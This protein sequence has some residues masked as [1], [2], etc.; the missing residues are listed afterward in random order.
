MAR[1]SVHVPGILR[2]ADAIRPYRRPCRRH[3]WHSPWHLLILLTLLLPL[4]LLGPAY[5][6]ERPAE[7]LIPVVHVLRADDAIYRLAAEG[8]YARVVQVFPWR[9]I[10]PTRGEWH[11]QQLDFA[12]R[13]AEYYGLGLIVRLDHPP[14]WALRPAGDK[15]ESPFDLDAYANFVATVARRYRGQVGAYII[16]NEPNLG[17]EWAG[18]R[19]DPVAY[20]ALLCWAYAALKAADPGATVVSAGLAPTNGGDAALDDRLFLRQMLEAGA[21]RCFDVLGAHAYSFGHP[22]DDPHGAHDGLNLARLLDL[23]EIMKAHGE[24]GKPVWITEIGWTTD[25]AGAHAWQT[26]SPEQ[27]AAYLMEA[28]RLIAEEWPWVQVLTIWNLSQGLPAGDEMAGYSLLAADGHP[29]PAYDAMRALL[30]AER[31]PGA[32]D[33]IECLTKAW[34]RAQIAEIPILAADEIVHLGDNQ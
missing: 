31:G 22:P 26:V 7:G 3:G 6:M 11:W 13:A 23:R 20:T 8:G 17:A 5:A 9:D 16:W 33:W 19:P 10:E 14:D 18:Q 15:G 4:L 32:A 34:R 1:G 27:Q 25:G 30:T 29:K 24:G 21:G 12:A 28:W 2:W